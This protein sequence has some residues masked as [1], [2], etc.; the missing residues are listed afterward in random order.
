MIPWHMNMVQYKHINM[1]GGKMSK[2]VRDVLKK[3]R[4][5]DKDALSEMSKKGKFKDPF[6]KQA[7]K[8]SLYE[9]RYRKEQRADPNKMPDDIADKFIEDRA[10]FD[11]FLE[12][13]YR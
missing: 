13:Y 5:T 3:L 10:V 7:Q 11:E 4:K 6:T 1:D 2:I 12:D 9:K 8:K